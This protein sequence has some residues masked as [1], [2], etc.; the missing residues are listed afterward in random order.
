MGND[1]WDGDRRVFQNVGK[2]RHLARG[3]VEWFHRKGD[4]ENVGKL[5]IDTTITGGGDRV[6][7]VE[8]SPSEE[9]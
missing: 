1:V 2:C 4:A 6:Q 5:R 3:L 8:G 7:F 9:G